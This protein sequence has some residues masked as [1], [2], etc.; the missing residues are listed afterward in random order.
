MISTDGSGLRGVDFYF[1]VVPWNRTR[2][3]HLSL[4]RFVSFSRTVP[5]MPDNA[6]GS[7]KNELKKQNKIQCNYVV[8]MTEGIEA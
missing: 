7:N 6:G 4:N 3:S 1:V 8:V 5:P 2:P